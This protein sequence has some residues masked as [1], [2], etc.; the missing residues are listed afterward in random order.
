MRT[1]ALGRQGLVVSELGL[2]CM[3]MSEFY[4]PGDDAESLATIDRALELGT[5]F[6]DTADVYG[7]GLNEQ[8]LGRAMRGRRDRFV[9][10]TKFGTVRLPDGTI[11][12]ADGRPEYVRA[13]CDASLRR[14]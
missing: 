14:L 4:G 6:F 3:G 2:G 12:G 10:A 13:C 7:L 8:L 9:L 5:T 11:V 1:R